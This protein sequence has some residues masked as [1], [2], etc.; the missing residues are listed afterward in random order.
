MRH[1]PGRRLLV[2]L[3]AAV[4]AAGA[5]GG[6]AYATGVVGAHSSGTV[7]VCVKQDTRNARFINAWSRCK[8]GEIAVFLQAALSTQ[9][10]QFTVRCDKGQRLGSLL[11]QIAKTPGTQPVTIT[12]YGNCAEDVSIGRDFVALKGGNSSA[13]I[14]SIS[15]YGARGAGLQV[16]TVGSLWVGDESMF[17]AG[18]MHFTGGVEVHDSHG[19]IDASA[20]DD[21]LK[22]GGGTLAVGGST[23]AHGDNGPVHCDAGSITLDNVDV[24]GSPGDG[25]DAWGSCQV[26]IDG[27]RVHDNT[28]FGVAAWESSS[29]RVQRGAVI[30]NNP[31]GGALTQSG[32][33]LWINDSIVRDNGSAGISGYMGGHINVSRSTVEGN[34]ASGLSLS[35][36]SSGGIDSTTIRN[37]SND[38]VEVMDTSVL[39]GNGGNTITGNT[40]WGVWCQPAP[41]TAQISGWDLGGLGTVSGNGDGQVSCPLSGQRPR[42]IVDCGNGDKLG[43]ALDQ[44][45]D[46]SEPVVFVVEGTCDEQVQ[47][48]RDNVT[49][50]IASPGDGV[51]G[52]ALNEVRGIQLWGL[53]IGSG[54]LHATASTFH[55]HTSHVSGGNTG[56]WLDTNSVGFV[57]MGSSV[58]N[59]SQTGV[60]VG[61]GSTLTMSDG[62]ITGNSMTGLTVRGGTEA[63]LS[64]VQIT[65][66]GSGVEIQW[67]GSANLNGCTVDNNQGQGVHSGGAANIVGG[68]VVDNGSSGVTAQQGDA[69]LQN[70]RVAT[71]QNGGV[72]GMNGARLTLQG[73]TVVEHNHGDGLA[74]M[75]GS[76][77]EIQDAVVIQSNDGNG[78][79]VRDNSVVSSSSAAQVVN[80]GGWGFWCT[81]NALISGFGGVGTVTGNGAGQVGCPVSS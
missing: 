30:D 6:I 20:L 12:V 66:N 68:E 24:S 11:D 58:E 76:S 48:D 69:N 14:R 45:A 75:I 13:S 36:G 80:N 27:G 63:T 46:R 78:V 25:V 64:N 54:G 81:S 62:S 43:D 67:G 51:R 77:A 52:L 18:S 47:I 29:I 61:S 2:A 38:G 70:T 26:T 56:I 21:G 49:L 71:N 59:A 65:G 3:V 41:A 5:V 73:T 31:R 50:K 34:D 35:G 53:A 10:T 39:T 17:S 7:T 4:V 15:I 8:K 60:M 23:I 79:N 55:A 42:V 37:N 32:G 9:P 72:I 44:F 40:D 28:S 19:Q 74:L 16:L 22:L 1:L 33:S 57:D